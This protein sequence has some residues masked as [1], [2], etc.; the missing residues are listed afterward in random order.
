MCG[1][2]SLVIGME[3]LVKRFGIARMEAGWVPRYNVAPTQT[4]PVVIG[5]DGSRELPG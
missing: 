4:M 1:R 5:Q 2:Y 3:Q